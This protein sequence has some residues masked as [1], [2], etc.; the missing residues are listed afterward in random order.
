L[1]NHQAEID[2]LERF[3]FGE[4]WRLFLDSVDESRI[5]ESQSSLLGMLGADDLNDLE[6]IDV[7]SGSG[8]SSLAA[9]HAGARVTSFDYDPL[10]VA[11]T[12]ELKRRF[13]DADPDW[14]ISEGSVLDRQFLASLGTFDVVYSWGVLHHTGDMWT[15]LGN[16]V[17]LVRPGGALFIAIY[18]DHGIVSRVWLRIKKF[19]CSSPRLV[20][21]ILLIAVGI[22][23]TAKSSLGRLARGDN[24]MPWLAWTRYRSGHRGMSWWRD[25]VDWVGGYP[26]EVAKPE[27]ILDFYRQSGFDLQRLKTSG[28]KLGCNEYVFRRMR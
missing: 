17:P 26:F 19:Y 14:N 11:C 7:G 2:A 1:A 15:A 18:N 24:P 23:L 4:N 6:F 16:I 12:R 21:W 28:G 3:Q 13:V 27:A 8:L 9:R 20:Q 22:Y 5:A 10:S 25:I